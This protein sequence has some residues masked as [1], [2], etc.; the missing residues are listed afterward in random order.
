MPAMT[1]SAV[2]MSMPT[3]IGKSRAIVAVGPRP[4]STPITV[5]MKAPMKTAPRLAGESAR[6][7]PWSSRLSVSTGS[8]WH[9]ISL[10]AGRQRQQAERQR[11][12]EQDLEDDQRE[13]RR[14][15]RDHDARA[16]GAAFD[17]AQLREQQEAG[18]QQI[19]ERL[20]QHD[21]ED[22]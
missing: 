4:G 15:R 2:T 12:L 9:G 22:E 11:D 21:V 13:R 5:P 10:P 7:K 19:A 6:A 14:G 3:V 17:E 1:I 8:P 18:R 16:P 20:E